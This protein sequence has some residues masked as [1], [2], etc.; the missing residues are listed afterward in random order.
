M[1]FT[2]VFFALFYPDPL[3]DPKHGS[4]KYSLIFLNVV[5]FIWEEFHFWDPLRGLGRRHLRLRPKQMQPR[6]PRQLQPPQL[7]DDSSKYLDYCMGLYMGYIRV[8]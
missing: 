5:G 2:S 8:V 6:P 1:Q 7:P 3:K 4:P